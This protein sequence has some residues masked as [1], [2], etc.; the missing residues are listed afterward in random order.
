MTFELWLEKVN[1]EFIDKT[2]IDRDSFPDQDYWVW[3]EEGLT[4]GEA[5]YNAIENEYG[6]EG[7]EAFGLES[8]ME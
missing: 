6:R 2:G 7:L 4:P 8:D 5:V 1:N 3:Y